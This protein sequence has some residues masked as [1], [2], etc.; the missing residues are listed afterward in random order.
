MGDHVL[1]FSDGLYSINPAVGIRCD[2]FDMM[3]FVEKARLMAPQDARTE[4]LFTK[5]SDL[6]QG[7]FLPTMHMAWV[8]SHRFRLQ[9]AYLEAL[10]G[11]SHC[12][13]AW[14]DYR[15]AEELLHQALTLEP[16]REDVHRLVLRCYA[17]AGK[18][19]QLLMHYD[20]MLRLFERDLK[21]RPAAETLDLIQSL[22]R[23]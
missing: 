9:E 20:H 12:R 3:T 14:E 19:Q 10:L 18:R 6:Y 7:E 11:R 22:L 4:E 21:T 13:L 1:I 2:A 15:A 16:Y 8:T 17:A 5:A 23:S